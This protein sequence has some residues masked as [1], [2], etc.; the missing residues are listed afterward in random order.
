[1]HRTAD[2][3]HLQLMWTRAPYQDQMIIPIPCKEGSRCVSI[4]EK[5]VAML[6]DT[7][8]T[9]FI[10][11]G[12]NSFLEFT[13]DEAKRLTEIAV[14]LRTMVWSAKKRQQDHLAKQSRAS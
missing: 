13:E 1:M 7:D 10:E 12:Q 8:R 3:A 6:K 5:G 4:L 11:V 2:E 14:E 9:P